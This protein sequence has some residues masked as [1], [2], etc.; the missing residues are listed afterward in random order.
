MH[1]LDFEAYKMTL[2]RKKT[3]VTAGALD[4]VKCTVIS[5]A[6]GSEDGSGIQRRFLFLALDED[7]WS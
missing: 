2:I 1:K 4:V 5:T 6:G 7:W 3:L